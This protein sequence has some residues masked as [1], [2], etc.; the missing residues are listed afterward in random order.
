[1]T[2]I[3]RTANVGQV[4]PRWMEWA[5]RLA[6]GWAAAYGGVRLWF[7]AGHAPDWKLPGRDLLIP[8]WISVAGCVLSV[9]GVVALARWP[10]SR[11][12]IGLLW[13]LAAGWVAVSGFALLD[14][15]GGVLPGLGIPFDLFGMLSRFGALAGAALLAGTALARQ[16]RLDPSCLRCTGR[17]RVN[18]TPGWA[19]AGALLAVAGC[20]ARLAAQAVVGFDAMP[21]DAG[22]AVVLFEVGFLLAGIALPLLLVLRLGN[23]FP[24]W[25]LLLPGAGLGAGI[26]AYFGVG[27]IQMIVA[28][29]QGKAVYG[30]MG[31]PDSFF[32]VAVPSYFVW[33]LGLA[34]AAYG[35]YLRTRKPCKGCGR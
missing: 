5:P 29:V 19:M 4:A 22:L 8:D 32:W 28:A 34:A 33:G 25:M 6:V 2:T 15:V 16:R 1:M 27:L 9:A 12:L 3:V 10:R 23:V 7:A 24:R 35:Y 30:D 26:T 18:S 13:A 17:A 31:L 11:V 14:V 21:Y 20:L